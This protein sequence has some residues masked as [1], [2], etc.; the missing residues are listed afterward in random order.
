MGAGFIL[1]NMYLSAGY[2]IIIDQ[3]DDEAVTL[4]GTCGEDRIRF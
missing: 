2:L 1:A 3:G 4:V